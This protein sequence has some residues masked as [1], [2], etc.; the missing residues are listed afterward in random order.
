MQCI[1][2]EPLFQVPCTRL[3]N[4]RFIVNP[5]PLVSPHGWFR[6]PDSL[7]L[8]EDQDGMEVTAAGI[9]ITDASPA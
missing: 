6:H 3:M 9:Q 2:K 4:C 7:R 8:S 5:A 1:V